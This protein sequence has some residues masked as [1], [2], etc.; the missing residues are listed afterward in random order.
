[1]FVTKKKLADMMLKLS[2]SVARD[3]GRNLS[4][5]QMKSLENR[6]Y[7]MLEEDKKKRKDE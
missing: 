3:C 2:V 1:M 7:S 5:K 6:I 4:I